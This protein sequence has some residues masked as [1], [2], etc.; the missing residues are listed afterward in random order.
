M[1]RR[2]A[3]HA[4]DKEY[5]AEVKLKIVLEYL[6]HPRSKKRICHEN[7]ITVDLLEQWH[8]EFMQ[9]AGQIFTADVP[10][11][12]A[13]PAQGKADGTV[14]PAPA[15]DAASSP[16]S[17]WGIRLNTTWP[18]S[19]PARARS[20]EVPPW[21]R[22][23]FRD[24]W[25]NQRG[26]VLW[27]NSEQ[28]MEIVGAAHAL[29]V[30]KEL[31]ED[32]IWRKKGLSIKS[33]V[34]YQKAAPEPPS[35]KTTKKKRRKGASVSD[36]ASAEPTTAP[37]VKREYEDREE[38][39]LHLSPSA[40]VEL[41]AF[42]QARETQLQ[43]MAEEDA[44]H[45]DFVMEQVLD[46]FLHAARGHEA[47]Q[48]D[49]SQR[50][51]TW[52]RQGEKNT[53][54]CDLPPNRGTV[55]PTSK[56][57]HWAACIERPDHFKDEDWFASLEEALTWA[58]QKLLASQK[59]DTEKPAPADA[60][61]SSDKPKMDLTPYHIDPAA[62]EPTRITYRAVIELERVPDHFKTMEMS[63][64]KVFR[65]A[66]EFPGPIRV[67][68]ELRLDEAVVTVTQTGLRSCGWNL[69]RSTATYYD[70]QV[71]AAQAQKLWEQSLVQ[72]FH[73]AKKI[74]QARYGVEEVETGYC[75]WLGA[76]EDPENRW[77]APE[78]RDEFMRD[79]AMNETITWALDVDRLRERMHFSPERWSD[80]KL[81]DILHHWRARSEDL[82][83]E[84]RAE[85]EQW[86]REHPDKS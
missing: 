82:P 18:G 5:G 24:Q 47:T 7:H 11:S 71:A 19:H 43:Q 29:R 70:M 59:E 83:A 31:R 80:E 3:A 60:E 41:L 68:R 32:D 14:T 9:K 50:P 21:P 45:M 49:F 56:N 20:P 35:K 23:Y 46:I 1:P 75:R 65:Y 77:P 15:K 55:Q 54:V 25:E 17:G 69:I 79:K 81:L 42:L 76:L 8:R 34:R 51:L 66:E 16:P 84:A 86:I 13:V 26:L 52:V 63:F 73:G 39:R 53:Y 62:L 2:T 74:T 58:E 27:N 30:L 64:G 37:E 61:P 40:A 78:S 10:P 38:E 57:L 12:L 36:E 28:K 67:A 33:V 48:M 85:S 4:A 22:G 72:Q 6:S 44:K